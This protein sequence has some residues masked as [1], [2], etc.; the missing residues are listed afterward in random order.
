MTPIAPFTHAVFV[1]GVCLTT[2]TGLTL[3]LVPGRTADYWAWTI[4][5][6]LTAA[7]FGAGYLGAAVALTLAARS[8]AW[9][10]VRVVA[11]AAFTLT[12]L[13]LLA[14]ALD[15]G[16]FDFGAGGLTE[17][18]AWIWLAV[19][20]AL[21]PAVL[22][23]F[24]VQER[25]SSGGDDLPSALP[26]TRVVC[27]AAGIALAVVGICLLA[28]WGWLVERWPWPLP[29]LPARV[30]GAWLC[31]YASGL[32]WFGLREPSW[33]RVRLGVGAPVL[34]LAL[35]VGAAVR[36]SGDLAGGA[37]TVIYLT[38]TS[39]LLVVLLGIW[40]IEEWRMSSVRGAGAT[41]SG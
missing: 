6:P 25:A 12:S 22:V 29:S 11:V 38:A 5:A 8:R 24:V 26:A 1:A 10:P 41:V 17:V 32:L 20:V 21:P 2:G 9:E 18:V 34:A 27:A 30:T 15:P 33:K 7:F 31:T 13:A 19:Y 23:A 36:H 40:G 3:Y 37:S 39:G 28:D 35:D 4:K 16:P 14:T